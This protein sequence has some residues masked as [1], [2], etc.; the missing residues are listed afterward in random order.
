M[1]RE[2]RAW[3]SN[4]ALA[5][6]V[7]AVI[8]LLVLMGQP[9]QAQTI[10]WK[11]DG[12]ASCTV[13]CTPGAAA[14]TPPGP[15]QPPVP[16]DPAP[17]PAPTDACAGMTPQFLAAID[18]VEPRLTLWD[19]QIYRNGGRV[20]TDAQ[21]ACARAR[22]VPGSQPPPPPA[23]NSDAGLPTT[24]FV[25]ATRGRPLT[26]T[27]AAGV[28]YQYAVPTTCGERVQLT[29]LEVVGTPDSISTTSTVRGPVGEILSGPSIFG[30]HGS[31]VVTSPCGT[32][33]LSVTPTVTAPLGVTRN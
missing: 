15:P 22:N 11:V 10:T 4:V 19:I 8:L 5:A 2:V 17:T 27:L 12:P 23:G 24:G 3:L 30:R 14:P 16:P 31:H 32:L 9:V 28:A 1:N 6:L 29:I 26:N 7:A 20:L 18:E 25:L 33:T 13:T 21:R